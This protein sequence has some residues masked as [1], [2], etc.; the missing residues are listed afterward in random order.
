V[1]FFKMI[2]Q[3]LRELQSNFVDS[4]TVELLAE[5]KNAIIDPRL[6][7][8]VKLFFVFYKEKIYKTINYL[9][10]SLILFG[11]LIFLT[12]ARIKQ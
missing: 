12:N 7:D 2:G 1:N 10:S 4:E 5:I 8:Q 3:H 9:S 11:M 6:M